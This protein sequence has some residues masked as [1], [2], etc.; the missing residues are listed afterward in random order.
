MSRYKQRGTDLAE[1]HSGARLALIEMP[2]LDEHADG[3][4]REWCLSGRLNADRQWF[5]Q[6]PLELVLQDNLVRAAKSNGDGF[7]WL[8]ASSIE[9][10]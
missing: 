7:E 9:V 5:A 6:M 4:V 10:R 2:V 8:S 3:A 1:Q